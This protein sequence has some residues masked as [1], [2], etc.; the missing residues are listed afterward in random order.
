VEAPDAA[1]L[2]VYG[3]TYRAYR[4]ARKALAPVWA[5]MARNEGAHAD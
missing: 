3:R 2:S 5:A 1:L 4:M